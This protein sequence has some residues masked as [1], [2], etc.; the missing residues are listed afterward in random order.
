MKILKPLTMV[1]IQIITGKQIKKLHKNF[2]YIK[3]WAVI[4]EHIIRHY[5]EGWADGYKLNIKYRELWNEPDLGDATWGG[6]KE[7]FFDLYVTAAKHL[8]ECF[9]DILNPPLNNGGLFY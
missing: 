9:P 2:I 3:K 1:D 6:T 4:C 5:N 8:R 7:Q